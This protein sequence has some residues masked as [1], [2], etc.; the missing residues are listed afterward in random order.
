MGLKQTRILDEN[1]VL[2][3]GIGTIGKFGY[4]SLKVTTNQQV[5]GVCFNKRRINPK[6]G[7]YLF[8]LMND[9]LNRNS[10]KVVISIL[11][12]SNLE[13]IKIPFSY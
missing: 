1:S 11:N 5:H 3:C 2:V 10:E 7:L 8:S 13:K 6:Y 4:S 9:E 12:K